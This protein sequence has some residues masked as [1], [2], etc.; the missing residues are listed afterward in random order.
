ML[1]PSGLLQVTAKGGPPKD[2][3]VTADAAPG[4]AGLFRALVL[5]PAGGAR[6][7]AADGD[8]PTELRV[9]A[10]RVAVEAVGGR[11]EPE[12]ADQE[13]HGA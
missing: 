10:L 1:R 4:S 5:T 13:Q 2:L 11:A 6:G 8:L 9:S 7:E 3:V 12:A